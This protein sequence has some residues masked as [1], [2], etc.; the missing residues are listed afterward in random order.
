MDTW[1]AMLFQEKL[2]YIRNMSEEEDKQEPQ[3]DQQ[4]QKRGLSQNPTLWFVLI[5]IPVLFALLNG[6][7]SK[8]TPAADEAASVAEAPAQPGE[9]SS[10]R[11]RYEAPVGGYPEITPAQLEACDFSAWEGLPFNKRALQS[12]GRPYRLVH[13]T[14]S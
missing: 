11:Q 8:R 5:C 1:L 13:R 9:E 4:E 2:H 12:V 6:A 3:N 10:V 14:D 7:L